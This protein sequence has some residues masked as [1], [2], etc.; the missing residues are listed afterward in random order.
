MYKPVILIGN[1]MRDNPEAVQELASR[2]VPILLTWMA[3]DLLPDDHPAYCGRPGMIGQRAANIIVQKCD[4]LFSYGARLDLETVGY[5]YDRFAPKAIR[6]IYDCDQAELDKLPYTSAKNTELLTMGNH[7]YGPWL[8]WCKSLNARYPVV[9]DEHRRKLAFINPYYFHDVLSDLLQPEDVIAIGSSGLAPCTFFQAFRVKAGQ[10]IANLCALGAM[11]ADVPMAIGECIGSGGRRTICVTGDGGFALNVVELEVARR[12]NLNIK[13]FVFDNCG[14]GSIRNMQ[15]S[16]F[17][18][19]HVACD[20]ESGMTLP[21]Y[22]TICMACGVA[23]YRI[24][25]PS[26]LHDDMKRVLETPGPAVCEISIPRDFT[27]EYKMGS[28]LKGDKFELDAYED[29]SPKLPADELAELMEWD[30]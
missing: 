9:T 29:L 12:L 16:R 18:G 19:H 25:F 14:Y 10:R 17:E 27:I 6:T 11:G 5:N 28:T 26:R 1:G 21:D 7:L 3:M 2:N 23:H 30:G 13:Y 22:E 24:A 8:T 15:N 4:H 20:M